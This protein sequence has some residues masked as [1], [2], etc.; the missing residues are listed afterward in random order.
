MLLSLRG[1][2]SRCWTLRSRTRPRWRSRSISSQPGL[3]SGRL[4][5]LVDVFLS[6]AIRAPAGGVFGEVFICKWFRSATVVLAYMVQEGVSLRKALVNLDVDNDDND[7]NNDDKTMFDFTG[8]VKARCETKQWIPPTASWMGATM[9]GRNL[10]SLI[11]HDWK[12]IVNVLKI[13]WFI[14]TFMTVS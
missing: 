9:P 1:L 7:D 5:P 2:G 3:G 10:L 8:E 12:Q 13:H 6:T 14:I 4:L 11:Y